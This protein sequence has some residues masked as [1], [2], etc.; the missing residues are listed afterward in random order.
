M[1]RAPRLSRTLDLKPSR[2]AMRK[3]TPLSPARRYQ[4]VPASGAW[5]DWLLA[6]PGRG[7]VSTRGERGHGPPNTGQ[8]TG[9]ADNL[10]DRFSLM[11]PNEDV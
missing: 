2:V 6:L 9:S 7:P 10:V 3:S 5:A 4:E 1:A 8:K 11:L